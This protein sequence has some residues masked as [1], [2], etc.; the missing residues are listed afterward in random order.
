[1]SDYQAVKDA[2]AWVQN[3]PEMEIL[4]EVARLRSVEKSTRLNKV[5]KEQ[6]DV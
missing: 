6:S 5:E 3:Q 1:M 4:R 2:I